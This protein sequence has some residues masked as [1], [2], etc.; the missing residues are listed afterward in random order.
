[1]MIIAT[2]KAIVLQARGPA[3][4]TVGKFLIIGEEQKSI[5][6]DICLRIAVQFEIYI[7]FPDFI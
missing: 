7:D 4:T 1:M 2:I 6:L 3:A 5:R